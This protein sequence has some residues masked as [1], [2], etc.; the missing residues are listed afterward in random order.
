MVQSANLAMFAGRQDE[1]IER[2]ERAGTLYAAA[3]EHVQSLMTRMSVCQAMSYAGRTT[4]AAARMREL[5]AS[6]QAIDNPTAIS[7]AHYVTGE[8][9]SRSD[10][11][12]AIA[13]YRSSAEQGRRSDNRLFVMLAHSARV[14]LVAHEGEPGE[15]LRELDSVL[16]QWSDLRNEAAVW[17][18]LAVLVAL[19]MRV[20]HLREAAILA[21]VV[22]ENRDRQPL[23]ER[24]EPALL[25]CLAQAE[26]RFGA[27]E[28]QHL[29]ATGA[30]MPA[31]AA[32]AHARR[33][34]RHAQDELTTDTQ[35]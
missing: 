9:L 21:T 32:V 16:G 7:W 6:A 8:T 10:P 13:A 17:G 20:G 12:A 22:R 33:A 11:A 14:T 30:G 26:E 1:A 4:E 25:A 29:V 2:F 27:E 23:W 3:G 15:A 35:R 28:A 31:D 24:N 19:L 5:L 34:I 18:V